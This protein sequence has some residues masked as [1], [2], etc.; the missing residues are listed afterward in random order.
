MIT[1]M[2]Q[3]FSMALADS[4][5]GVSGGTIAFILGFYE[6]FLG[7][8]HGLF[9]KDCSARKTSALYLLK[10]A[11]GWSLGMGLCVL[12]LSQVFK[13]NIYTMTSLFLGFTAAAV[14]FIAYAERKTLKG[15]YAY[16]LFTLLGAMFVI[17]LTWFRVRG[18]AEGGMD[19]LHLSGPQALYLFAAGVIAV[20]AMLLPGVSGS[21]LLLIFGVYVPAIGAVKEVMQMHLQFLPGIAVLMTGVLFGIFFAAKLIRKGL[22]RFRPQMV[23]LIIGMMMG[24]LY[25]IVSGPVT[26]DVPEPSLSVSTFHVAAFGAGVLILTGLEYLKYRLSA[27]TEKK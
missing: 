24:S 6:K 2:L 15:A 20:S 3:G 8:L 1:T 21:T 12:L 13:S 18:A 23:Y 22:R 11:A 27:K 25:S 4:V 17:L 14:P 7:A 19:F 26:L 16:A 9:G 10:F 5:P